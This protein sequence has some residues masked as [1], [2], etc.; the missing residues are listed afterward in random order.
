MATPSKAPWD[1]R[2]GPYGSLWVGPAQLPHPGR[3]HPRLEEKLAEREADA[4]LIGAALPM[5]A[6][7]Q[8]AETALIYAISLCDDPR[9]RDRLNAKVNTI[10]AAIAM[11]KGP[12]DPAAVFQPKIACE[13]ERQ[14]AEKVV[15]SFLARGWSVSVNDGEETVLDRSTDLAAIA[16][17]MAT[18][19]ENTLF[20]YSAD[21]KKCGFVWL[22]Y[23]NGCD[24]I[25]DYTANAKMEEA[26][27]EAQALADRFSGAEAA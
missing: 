13:M 3:E 27:A 20:A 21:G 14:V 11:A 5:L 19:D 24:V 15:R 12:L 17:A 10:R 2:P 26:L 8:E 16:A 1:K 23:G 18:T 4:A 22:I 7:L 6:A 9:M 25:S